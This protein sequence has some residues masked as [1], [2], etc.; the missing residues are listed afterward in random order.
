MNKQKLFIERS[1]ALSPSE[2][3]SLFFYDKQSIIIILSWCV[4][5]GGAGDE[6]C[7]GVCVC[8]CG[9]CVGA[10]AL[11]ILPRTFIWQHHDTPRTLHLPRTQ[12]RVLGKHWLK[13]PKTSCFTILGGS[14]LRGPQWTSN[15]TY[16]C[17]DIRVL[18]NISKASRGGVG[19]C[20]GGC[21]C[22][23]EIPSYTHVVVNQVKVLSNIHWRW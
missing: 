10:F 3:N 8:V 13:T 17:E 9:V 5:G 20:V 11:L 1:P 16:I 15:L 7:V 12:K 19:V 2:H 18:G 23:C 6:V 21:V 14:A 4:G 22:V